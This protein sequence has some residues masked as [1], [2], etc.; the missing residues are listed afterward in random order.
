MKRLSRDTLHDLS[1]VLML[2]KA[3]RDRLLQM[4]DR[5]TA[6]V[7]GVGAKSLTGAAAYGSIM[8]GIGSFGTAGTGAAI[9]G[10]GG[11]AKTTAS[12]YWLG[13]IVG[14]GVAAGSA[15]L[16]AGTVGAGIYGAVRLRRA[17]LG[18]AR[19]PDDLSAD[20]AR[21]LA[22]INIMI[23]AI[24]NSLKSGNRITRQDLALFARIGIKPLLQ[25]L[26]DALSAQAFASLK[27]VH[28]V[29]LRG[30][31]KILSDLQSV[32]DPS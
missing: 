22:A 7:V 31:V 9:A 10:L 13:G 26:E 5:K 32:L 25:T 15:V 18:S 14:G 16:T 24:Q 20:E 23:L 6:L 8:A 28:R 30:H 11:A 17:M 21:I 1:R 2:L 4:P 12:L 27:T 29:R 3:I 19:N